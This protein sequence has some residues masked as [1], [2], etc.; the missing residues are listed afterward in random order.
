MKEAFNNLPP[1]AHSHY[2]IVKAGEA[3]TDQD[4]WYFDPWPMF[5]PLLFVYDPVMAD[6]VVNHPY[7]GARKPRALEAWMKDI[8]GG[9][10]MFDANGDGWK[11]LHEMVSPCFSAAN[12]YA[13]VSTVMDNIMVFKELLREKAVS[14]EMFELE[15]Y[16]KNLVIDNIG[17]LLLHTRLNVQKKP[18]KL[19]EAM[20]RQLNMKFTAHNIDIFTPMAIYEQWS[21]SRRLDGYIKD[22][23]VNRFNELTA[24]AKAG[25][26]GGEGGFRS[27]MDQILEDYI[28]TNPLRTSLDKNFLTMA[29]RNMRMLFFVSYDS[30]AAA[31]VYCIYNLSRN[32]S[33][34]AK[35]R[36]EHSAVLGPNP[37]AAAERIR[38]TPAILNALPYTLAVIK[39]SMRIFP[40]AGSIREGSADLV[41]TNSK[42][43]KFPTE[44]FSVQVVHWVT[45]TSEKYW[46]RPREFL[47]ERFLVGP[48]HELYPPKGAWRAFEFGPRMCLGQQLVYTEMKA[49][50]ACVV[51]EF[52]FME[53]YEEAF[54]QGGELDLSEVGGERV[55]MVEAGAAHPVG[56]FPCRV[57]TR[58]V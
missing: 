27:I 57:K 34:L 51:R 19:A 36:A 25:I 55:Y 15:P 45:H 4:G 13:E 50:L 12:V 31:I 2:A 33:T 39:E 49:V 9:S 26:K 32:P 48:D 40:P 44:G 42:G 47:P 22:V 53:C 16:V 8:A 46:K 37:S 10:T 21:N 38:A 41:L 56:G 3:F 29:A 58:E 30:S 6:K 14:G 20:I 54:G 7:V 35:I 24:D 1:R 17:N 52:E 11:Y 18:H 23:L 5:D 43:Q 28:A